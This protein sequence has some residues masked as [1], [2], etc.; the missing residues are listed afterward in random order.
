MGL[1]MPNG[2]RAVS[3]IEYIVDH[4]KAEDYK[5]IWLSENQDN[6]KRM[7]GCGRAARFVYRLS[8]TSAEG[9]S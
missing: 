6:R 7:S 2:T 9:T 3:S 8:V 1:A 4:I 5:A